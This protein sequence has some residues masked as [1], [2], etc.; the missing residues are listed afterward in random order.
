MSYDFET[1]AELR[2]WP[3][4][5]R[6]KK[7]GRS[8]GIRTAKSGHEGFA[9]NQKK[10]RPK[11]V[12]CYACPPMGGRASARCWRMKPGARRAEERL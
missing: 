10:N 8:N 12:F 1:R 9:K 5:F 11:A 3:V 4:F 2:T 7:R 6:S